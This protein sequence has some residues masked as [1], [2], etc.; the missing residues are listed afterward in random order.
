[1]LKAEKYIRTIGV[2]VTSPRIFRANDGLFYV[3]K[4]QRNRLGPKV[5]AN[6]LLAAKMGEKLDLCFPPGGVME[7]DSEVILRYPELARDGILP[8]KQF[9]CLYLPHS[10]YV[11]RRKLSKAVNKQQLAGVMLFDHL[12]H[13]MDRTWNRKNLLIRREEAGARVYAIDN[14]HLFMRGRWTVNSLR[15]LAGRFEVNH[16]RS[17]GVLLKHYLKPADFQP[18]AQAIQQLSNEEIAG[19]VE[20]I[21][22]EWLP[23]QAERLALA[24]HII[25]RRNLVPEICRHLFALIPDI[26]RSPDYD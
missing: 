10:Y 12:L 16:C 17:Y 9:A 8:G 22:L 21:P 5:L 1:M 4:L 15:K 11:D 23:D 14:S 7:L 25:S 3:V 18:Y 19:F 2:G 20:Q 13:N 26:N 6:E 24:E